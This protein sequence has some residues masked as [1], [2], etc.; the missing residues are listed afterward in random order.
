MTI[1]PNEM[2]WLTNALMVFA[3]V[4]FVVLVLAILLAVFDCLA[5]DIA[6]AQQVRA[7]TRKPVARTYCPLCVFAYTTAT[8]PSDRWMPWLFAGEPVPCAAHAGE[9]GVMV[10]GL[11]SPQT[12]EPVNSDTAAS[13]AVESNDVTLSDR[14]DRHITQEMEAAS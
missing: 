5:E 4:V 3:G 13:A 6:G 7:V 12:H 2:D 11:W 9:Y 8:L 10:H 14:H 1:G